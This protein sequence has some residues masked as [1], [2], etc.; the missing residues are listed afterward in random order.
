MQFSFICSASV[1]N[2]LKHQLK[3]KKRALKEGIC[4]IFYMGSLHEVEAPKICTHTV[5]APLLYT[6]VLTGFLEARYQAN[7]ETNPSF[8]RLLLC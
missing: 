4:S 5:N 2:F 3:E 8:A 1:A 7:T 6:F